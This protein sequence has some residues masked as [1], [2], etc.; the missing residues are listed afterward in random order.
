MISVCMAT[1]NGEKYLEEQLKSII[2]QLN[3][4]D[5]I[6]ISDDGSTDNTLDL[7]KKYQDKFSNIKFIN[8]PQKGV[9]KNFE[10]AINFAKGDII[11]LCDQDDIWYENKVEIVLK[12]FE[13]K[14]TYLI[15]HD[16]NIVNCFGEKIENSFFQHRHSKKGIIRN[17]WK[18]SYLGC[19]MAFRKEVIRKALPFP[20]KIEMHDWW[21]GIITEKYWST[22]LITDKL[23]GYRRH[24]NNVSSF[25]HHPLKKMLINRI[26]IIYKLLMR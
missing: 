24:G 8:G 4:T 16:A 13:N 26:Y 12:Y 14:D 20:E 19:C 18:N 21:L 3:P 25:H 5:E 6:I 22:Y 11:F 9:V 15:L 17:I 23:I 7:V 1:Y 10:N 2:L